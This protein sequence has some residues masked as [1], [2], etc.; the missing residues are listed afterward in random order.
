MTELMQLIKDRQGET[1]SEVYANQIGIR[2][3]TLHRY[4]IGDREIGLEALR[5]MFDFYRQRGDTEMLIA[6]GAY[7]F[8]IQPEQLEIKV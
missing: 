6:L 1:P 5:K 8:R 7:A 4:H 3:N 2:G